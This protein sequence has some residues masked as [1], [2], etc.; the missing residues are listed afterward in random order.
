MSKHSSASLLKF[1][2]DIELE[3][4]VENDM[5]TTTIVKYRMKDKSLM[6]SC[7]EP[8]EINATGEKL[9]GVRLVPFEEL[10]DVI[11]ERIAILDAVGD[12]TKVERVGRRREMSLLA[13]HVYMLDMEESP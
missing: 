5:S 2:H 3:E 10:P 8:I 12:G 1:L 13:G 9:T 11:Q 4:M 7:Y 6:Y